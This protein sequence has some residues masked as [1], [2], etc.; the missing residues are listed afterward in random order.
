MKRFVSIFS[1]LL[2]ISMGAWGQ[3]M[4]IV[5]GTVTDSANTAVSNFPVFIESLDAGGNVTTSFVMSDAFGFYSDTLNTQ[6]TQFDSVTIGYTLCLPQVITHV[7]FSN[8][9]TNITHNIVTCGNSGGGGGGTPICDATFAPINLVGGSFLFLSNS[10]GPNLTYSWDFGDG[11]TSAQSSPNYT[12]QASG[13]YNVCLIVSGTNCADTSCQSIVVTTNGGGGGGNPN[14]DASFQSLALGSQYFFVSNSSGLP[15]YTHS[16]TF[17]DGNS[18]SQASPNHVYTTSGTYNVCHIILGPNCSDTSCQSITVNTGGGGG[19]SNCSAFFFAFPDSNINDW[20]FFPIDTSL[21]SYNWIFGDGTTSNQMTPTHSYATTGNYMVCLAVSDGSGCVDTFCQPIQVVAPPNPCD[22]SFTVAP[23]GSL[24]CF[25]PTNANAF[26]YNWTFGDGNSST[27]SHPNHQ[28]ASSGTYNVCLIVD[29]GNGC[30]DT[31][32]QT[33]TVQ[34]GG[35]GNPW[36]D[37][38]FFLHLTRTYIPGLFI[39]LILHILL[40]NGHLVMAIQVQLYFLLIPMPQLALLP[41]AS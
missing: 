22:A 15:G 27:A 35:G 37:A 26:S 33:I 1:L 18:S 25:F 11:N 5:S 34:S 13:T 23:L 17:G 38:T 21:A 28:Y 40:S 24:V 10:V 19:G 30:Q 16:W 9:T 2:L 6:S 32:C 31:S 39:H 36:C 12:Y 7:A 29:D 8:V 41:F 3:V 14:C 4:V 20:N